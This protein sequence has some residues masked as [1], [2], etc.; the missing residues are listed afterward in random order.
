MKNGKGKKKGDNEKEIT[1]WKRWGKWKHKH[2]QKTQFI[3]LNYIYIRL[4][5]H[6]ICIWIFL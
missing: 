6:L 1:A 2:I 4:S 5:L 3:Y